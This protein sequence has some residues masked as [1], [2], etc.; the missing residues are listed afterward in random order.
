MEKKGYIINKIKKMKGEYAIDVDLSQHTYYKIGG[1]ADILFYPK[2]EQELISALS[3]AI[4]NDYPYYIL[5]NG[6]N[7]LV[8]D[9]GFNGIVI[10]LSCFD[11]IQRDGFTVSCGAGVDLD[12][13]IL[14]CEERNL[15]GIHCLSG[16][17]GSVGGATHMNAGTNDG[18][19]GNA[20]VT[21]HCINEKLNLISIEKNRINFEYRNVPELKGKIITG[22]VLEL[23]SEKSSK[24]KSQRENQLRRR[25][26]KQ[27]LEY[28]SCGSVFK[29]PS[30]GYAS[31]MIDEAGLKGLK[32][33]DAMISDKH[34]GF[35]VNLGEATASDVIFLIN[36]IQETIYNKY[37]IF[38]EPEV[39]FLGF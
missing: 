5:G 23:Y 16:I 29:R 11:L 7:V 28:G 20:I 31:Q 22:C 35:I 33:G 6:S 27:P 3:I 36:K 34:A 21:V 15:G 12:R 2:D 13:L 38:L 9:K 17:P 26:E 32:K 8:N 14:F 25:L 39:K 1:P 30:K 37:S 19:I 4:E 10:K 18:E 24:L